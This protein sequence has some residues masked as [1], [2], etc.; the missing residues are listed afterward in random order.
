M[1]RLLSCFLLCVLIISVVATLFTAMYVVPKL[2]ESFE[3]YELALPRITKHV[4]ALSYWTKM[5]WP[6]VLLVMLPLIVGLI[7]LEVLVKNKQRTVATYALLFVTVAC[8]LVYGLVAMILP[9]MRPA[10]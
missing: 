7:V 6:W 10:C 5:H 2:R 4:L 3:G 8:V 9:F 1:H